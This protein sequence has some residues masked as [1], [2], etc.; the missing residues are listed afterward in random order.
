MTVSLFILLTDCFT[1]S[2]TTTYKSIVL[3]ERDV[4]LSRWQW[5]LLL[6]NRLLRHV[7]LVNMA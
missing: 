4:N 5:L 2:P 3:Y 6:P 7:H 1:I